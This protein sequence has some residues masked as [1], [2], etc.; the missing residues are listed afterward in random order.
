MAPD[1]R[2]SGAISDES[3]I[4]K[5]AHLY[6]GYIPCRIFKNISYGQLGITNSWS[7]NDLFGGAIVYDSDIKN[8]F[9]KAQDQRSNKSLVLEQMSYVKTN[10]TYL[11]RVAAIL[12]IL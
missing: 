1:I 6:T 10:H 8:L 12:S 4:T 3:D 5:S 7:V 11:N 9:Y 2:G